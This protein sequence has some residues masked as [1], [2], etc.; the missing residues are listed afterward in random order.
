MGEHVDGETF[1]LLDFTAQ[2]SGGTQACFIRRPEEHR[3]ALSAFFA[4]NGN[5]YARYNYLGEWH[6]H[7]SFAPIPS[8][9]DCET[10]QEIAGDAEVGAHFVVLLV[11]KLQ[12]KNDMA[13]SASLFRKHVD[14][15][16]MPVKVEPPEKC[17]N[18]RSWLLAIRR[19]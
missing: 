5:D 19:R 18:L 15:V 17:S 13:L 1:R 8:T 9:T 4:K 2:M 16:D 3:K 12:G 6:S 7:P 10:M 11:I 14:P